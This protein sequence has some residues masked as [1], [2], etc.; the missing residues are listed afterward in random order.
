MGGYVYAAKLKKI[1]I[2]DLLRVKKCPKC[3]RVYRVDFKGNNGKYF[4][5]DCGNDVL[6]DHP[7]KY[8]QR[9]FNFLSTLGCIMWLLGVLLVF[10]G[11]PYAC[12]KIISSYKDKTATEPLNK[13]TNR[14]IDV[15]V[16]SRNAVRAR[17]KSPGTAEFGEA[18][19]SEPASGIYII[20]SYV[21][22]QNSFGAMIRMK[23]FCK[24][25]AKGKDFELIQLTFE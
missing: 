24:I 2:N 16:Y 13:F 17:L 1:K 9:L 14:D 3:G 21:D 10:G 7:S 4:T 11:I 22:S 12:Y 5:C 8:H 15:L 6:I 18:Y 25:Q 20:R 23:Y 19:I